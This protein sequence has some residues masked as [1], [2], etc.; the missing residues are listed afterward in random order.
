MDVRH[1]LVVDDD[2]GIRQ[3]ITMLL[4][5][6]GYTVSSAAD[7]L[8]ALEWLTHAEADA[9]LLD[10]QM[11]NCDGHA[12]ATAYRQRPGP[13]SP[14]ILLTAS[15]DLRERCRRVEADGCL[16]KPFDVESLFTAIAQQTHDHPR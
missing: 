2:P 6:E 11:P 5:E 12:F 15:H 14:I 13:A 7:G 4:E 16:A 8:E 1:V 9:I 10:Y 3:V